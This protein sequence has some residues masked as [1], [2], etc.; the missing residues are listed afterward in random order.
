M[1]NRH[2]GGEKEGDSY[3]EPPQRNEKNLCENPG[4][5]EITLHLEQNKRKSVIYNGGV[6]KY[7]TTFAKA[8]ILYFNK[9]GSVAKTQ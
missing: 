4:F 1:K 6:L 3:R 9:T 8:N 7:D 5:L 2:K